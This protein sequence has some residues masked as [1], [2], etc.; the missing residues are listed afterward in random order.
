MIILI[1]TIIIK[2]MNMIQKQIIIIK[3][4]LIIKMLFIKEQEHLIGNILF[5]EKQRKKI[6]L[7]ILSVFLITLNQIIKII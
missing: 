4:E 7:I 2:I 3:G 6:A 5:I 1:I